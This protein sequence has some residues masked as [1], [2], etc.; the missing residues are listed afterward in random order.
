MI[1]VKIHI[2]Q[3]VIF[4]WYL[5]LILPNSLQTWL[6]LNSIM[7]LHRCET[8]QTVF[9]SR[10]Y[11]SRHRLR[12]HAKRVCRWCEKSED[13]Q[14]RMKQHV[15]RC[16]PWVD[17]QKQESLYR[18][19]ETDE[20][21]LPSFPTPLRSPQGACYDPTV[22]EYCITYSPEGPQPIAD[23]QPTSGPQYSPVSS[24]QSDSQSD[25]DLITQAMTLSGLPLATS[26]PH[27][28]L[29][30][31]Q[32]DRLTTIREA[33]GP[34]SV[35]AGASP[36]EY[37]TVQNTATPVGAKGAEKGACPVAEAIPTELQTAIAVDPLEG[38][39]SPATS[40]SSQGMRPKR[41]VLIPRRVVAS[42]IV[43]SDT[44]NGPINLSKP[45]AA[46]ASHNVTLPQRT[47]I[48]QLSTSI[49]S[50]DQESSGS[51]EDSPVGLPESDAV[52]MDL[53]F[54]PSPMPGDAATVEMVLRPA[55][56]RATP[57]QVNPMDLTV[58][59]RHSDRS[60]TRYPRQDT[61]Q[62]VLRGPNQHISRNP[63]RAWS[64]LVNQFTTV[65]FLKKK[66]GALPV[67]HYVTWLVVHFMDVVHWY[68]WP[69]FV[70]LF[71]LWFFLDV[72]LYSIE[73][74]FDIIV[75]L[76]SLFVSDFFFLYSS[77]RAILLLHVFTGNCIVISSISHHW[78][79]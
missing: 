15:E 44:K 66:K 25:Q 24:V 38:K 28:E 76:T 72:I 54:R 73:V 8:C 11:L 33:V 63:E 7:A 12:H 67:L 49:N 13:R 10:K 19:R 79:G 2:I 30:G 55:A 50:I 61:R 29:A 70:M 9:T 35:R 16:H 74:Y 32:T 75:F 4:L 3:I 69:V 23:Y 27:E 41:T 17:L 21:E 60:S 26:S 52:P 53:T 46:L 5:C 64:A 62:V 37:R 71:I 56:R 39:V 6:M 14:Y 20:V 34:V 36:E 57:E 78:P 43:G 68:L 18:A 77:I 42:T 31:E 59:R 58:P 48:N 65:R 40:E 22:Q 51:S 47:I 1:T 45:K